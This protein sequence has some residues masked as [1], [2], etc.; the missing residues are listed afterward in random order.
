MALATLY[1]PQEYICQRFIH[2]LMFKHT[3][4][5]QTVINGLMCL[6]LQRGERL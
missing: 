6:P 2:N 4:H 5:Y 1:C 3:F